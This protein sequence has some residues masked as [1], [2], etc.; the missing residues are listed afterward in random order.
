LRSET[1]AVATLAMVMFGLGQ[2]GDGNR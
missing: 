1:A 2:M